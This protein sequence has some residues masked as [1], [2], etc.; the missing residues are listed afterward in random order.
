MPKR[1]SVDEISKLS[2]PV[3]TTTANGLYTYSM[4]LGGKSLH[5]WVEVTHQ[6]FT[7]EYGWKNTLLKPGSFGYDNL[8]CSV[9]HCYDK[10]LEQIVIGNV[11]TKHAAEWVHDGWVMN[12]TYWRD[13][14]PWENQAYSKPSSPL[15]DVRRDELANTAYLDLPLDEQ[16]KDLIVAEC[17]L[18]NIEI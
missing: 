5:Q 18:T 7:K 9:A 1:K 8:V 6:A 2:I 17:I 13:N 15:G 12:Y 16:R 14:K 10:I 3:A 11:E 4:I